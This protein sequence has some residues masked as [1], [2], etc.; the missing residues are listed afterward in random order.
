[1]TD[2]AAS[3]YTVSV[4]PV[5]AGTINPSTGMLTLALDPGD[6]VIEV[7]A[8]HK[9]FPS[10]KAV[11][12]II[13]TP[14]LMGLVISQVS[15]TAVVGSPEL[16]SITDSITITNPDVAGVCRVD[17]VPQGAIT[18]ALA[19]DVEGPD[20]SSMEISLV[21][22]VLTV[23]PSAPF[24]SDENKITI[25]TNP[26]SDIFRTYIIKTGPKLKTIVS[27]D[28]QPK[29]VPAL[30]Y[31]DTVQFTG[32]VNYSDGSTSNDVLFYCPLGKGTL[33]G[34]GVYTAPQYDVAGPFT[35]EARASDKTTIKDTATIA[36]VS[37][38]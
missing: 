12:G 32:I 10:V 1:M 28:I 23:T 17:G 21:N 15:N 14:K 4:L 24:T 35:V 19:Y 33:L 29:T 20:A 37:A 18:G 22:N 8:V 13:A 36:G 16:P 9:E 7:T 27:V 31:G 25:R 2:S 26:G 11:C 3:D 38:P 30:S 5:D 6:E 34:T